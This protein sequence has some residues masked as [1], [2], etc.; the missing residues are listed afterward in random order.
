MLCH[1]VLCYDV[2][3][4]AVLNCAMLWYAMGVLD[5]VW[6]LSCHVPGGC[7]MYQDHG[8]TA[9]HKINVAMWGSFP[10]TSLV[11][12]DTSKVKL[13]TFRIQWDTSRVHLNTCRVHLRTPRVHLST[14]RVHLNVIPESWQLYPPMIHA[15]ILEWQ[16]IY[17]YQCSLPNSIQLNGA[18]LKSRLAKT[19]LASMSIAMLP[20][21]AT[22][23]SLSLLGLLG[24]LLWDIALSYLLWDIALSL[25]CKWLE[26]CA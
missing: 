22:T 12:L 18:K 13:N 25:C 7:S 5:C 1:D 24:D 26:R 17:V 16:D 2:L 6:L 10:L 21:L 19:R 23:P 20:W 3:C 8:C 15:C 9:A 11:H 14:S 4:Y